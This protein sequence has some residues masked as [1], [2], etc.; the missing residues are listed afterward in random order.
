MMQKM[1]LSSLAKVMK[2][3]DPASLALML[4]Y[5]EPSRAEEFLMQFPKDV[6]E[7]VMEHLF[8]LEKEE[9]G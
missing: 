3:E 8:L 7:K 2:Q 9:N 5:L 6:Q 1:D 4:S